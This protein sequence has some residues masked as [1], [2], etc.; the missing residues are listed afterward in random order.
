MV[1]CLRISQTQVH[2]R[3]MRLAWPLSVGKFLA[4]SGQISWGPPSHHSFPGDPPQ[5]P[6]PT[7]LPF[8]KHAFVWE[9]VCVCICC[10][11]VLRFISVSHKYRRPLG[12]KP[13]LARRPLEV[14]PALH[15]S[16][17]SYEWMG[18]GDWTSA[19]DPLSIMVSQ[20]SDPASAF[21][22]QEQKSHSA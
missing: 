4:A 5:P 7:V 8:T 14:L 9:V 18:T 3:A 6:F 1:P 13:A 2:R 17:M 15:I 12:E 11:L 20:E 21:L 22:F 16:Q 19:A 10:L